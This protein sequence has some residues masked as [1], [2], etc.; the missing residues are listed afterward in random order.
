MAEE[1]ALITAVANLQTRLRNSDATLKAK[2]E[3]HSENARSIQ[4]LQ[5]QLETHRKKLKAQE[6]LA[7]DKDEALQ[8]YANILVINQ[9]C[10]EKQDE[11]MQEI[12]T[13]NQRVLQLQLDKD[14]LEAEKTSMRSRKEFAAGLHSLVVN[15]SD[16]LVDAKAAA[17]QALRE[18]AHFP[19]PRPTR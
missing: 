19:G 15:L 11:H 5:Q 3:Q 7:K 1:E 13:L 4:N 8:L 14:K 2:Q 10:Q 12:Q 18:V 6:K 17:R 9:Q 16:Q